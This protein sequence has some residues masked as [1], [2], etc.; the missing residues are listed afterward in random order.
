MAIGDTISADE[1]RKRYQAR[2]P[3]KRK[4]TL[5]QKLGSFGEGLGRVVGG[6][7]IG[8]A[9][10]TAFA[11]RS[12][13]ARELESAP[14]IMRGGRE[15][16]P[17]GNGRRT[18]EGPSGRAIAGDVLKSATTIASAALPGAG[19]LAG[20]VAQGVGFGYASDVAEGVISGE[21][22][23]LR[24]GIGTALGGALPLATA[25]VG[26]LV[27]R[28]VALTSGAGREV[29]DRAIHNPDAV[30]DAITQYARNDSS[31]QA[32][33]SRAKAAIYDFLEARSTEYGD[34]LATI[35]KNTLTMKNG[36][37]YLRRLPVGDEAKIPGYKG[38]AALY[39]NDFT[40]KGLKDTFTK[41]MK[42]IGAK[43]SGKTFDFKEVALPSQ[44][45]RRLNELAERIYEWDNF[46]PT[47]LEKVRQIIDSYDTNGRV[48][49]MDRIVR[50]LK[51]NVA[52]YVDPKVPMLRTMR[53]TYSAKS[54][55]A[56]GVLK[57]LNLSN[58]AKPSTQLNSIMRLFKKDPQVA[59][60]LA[61]VMGKEKADEFLNELSGAILSEWLPSGA[62]R[63]LV[64]GL[65][66]VGGA[67]GVATGSVSL[68]AAAAAAATASPR[69]VGRAATKAGKL[70]RTGA[71]TL[72]RRSA[73]VGG[74]RLNR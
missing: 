39:P 59:E 13:A 37:Q 25:L 67:I 72:L 6:N 55:V 2:Q 42:E 43:G 60:D 53:E 63:Q 18:F 7:V 28:G 35:E 22:N 23:P 21:R 73:A 1:F 52:N 46:K 44:E 3:E 4:K 34:N 45:T 70:I 54:R 71:G 41:T 66:T 27:K 29:I 17:A 62:V 8:D 20:K 51:D 9:I 36:S 47:G 68:P 64:E 10:G 69:I 49:Q 38:G 65:G 14:A 15:I 11:N 32:L 33:V 61:K 56:E 40:L 31:K 30:N 74:P 58:N 12:A 26:T 57:E 16:V 48:P 19:S 5:M 24:P 50:K